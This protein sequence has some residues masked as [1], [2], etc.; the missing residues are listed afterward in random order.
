MSQL[1]SKYMRSTCVAM[2]AVLASYGSALLI[3]RLAGLRLDIVIWAIVLTMTLAR[4]QRSAGLADRLAGFV[5]LPAVAVTAWGIGHLMSAHPGAGDGLFVVAMA[6]SVWVRRFGPRAGQAGGLIVSPLI[7]VL[8]VGAGGPGQAGAGW[9]AVIAVV[10]CGWVTAFSLLAVRLTFTRPGARLTSAGSAGSAGSWRRP[11]SWP[12]STRM[13]LQLGTALAAAFAVGR[14]TWPDHW[15]WVV[16]TAFIVG[17]GARG[18]GDVLLKG[19]LRVAG[20]AAGT[21]AGAAIA[22]TLGPR[23]DVTV[24]LMF[25][26][27]AVATWL[28]EYSYAYWA[29][30]ITT[31]LSLLYGWF[32]QSADAL[33][34][35][36]LLGILVGAALGIGASWLILPVRTGDVLR[37]RSADAVAAIGAV[38]SADPDGVAAFERSVLLLDQIAP[39][40][41][42]QRLL[43]SRRRPGRRYGAD[44]ID[45]IAGCAVPVRTFAAAAPGT[46]DKDVAALIAGVRGSVT[47]A[48]LAIGRRPPGQPACVSFPEEADVVTAAL[49]DIERALRAVCA[50]L[51]VPAGGNA[52]GAAALGAVHDGQGK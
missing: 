50:A 51:T 14:I 28:R 46:G 16:L 19:I 41:R 21:A 30:I 39:P 10:A 38:L 22:G 24:A 17:S 48:R 27:L 18:R 12:A 26:A 35:T 7:A 42:A 34:P 13:A 33:L 23:A 37:R 29:A 45:A 47:A 1:N 32:G 4:V 9:V 11:R 44:A 40:L 8:I 6:G 52:G 43:L 20:A 5:L 25:L 31:V 49:R 3:E 36:R 2:A 15:A